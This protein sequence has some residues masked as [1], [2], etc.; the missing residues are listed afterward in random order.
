MWSAPPR[1]TQHS[2]T[3]GEE[4][5]N[6]QGNLLLCF[7]VKTSDIGIT[8]PVGRSGDILEVVSVSASTP[9]QEGENKSEEEEQ[10]EVTRRRRNR[11]ST[12]NE[13]PSDKLSNSYVPEKLEEETE[14]TE[15]YEYEEDGL[16]L[17]RT[18][19]DEERLQV[20]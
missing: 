4:H 16:A 18:L 14:D 9:K 7:R 6:L 5:I 1:T 12:D 11:L 2:S 10:E 15:E 17:L 3:Q 8:A 20:E 19:N 13:Q